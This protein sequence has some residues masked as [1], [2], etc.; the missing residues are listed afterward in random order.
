MQANENATAL[1]TGG[2]GFIGSEVIKQ[3]LEKGLSVRA[4][5]RKTSPRQ[6]LEGLKFETAIGELNDY[7][8][9]K[10]AVRGVDYVFHIAGVVS[11][12][13]REEYFRSNAEGTGNLAK[14]CAEVNSTLKRFIYVSSL[15]ASG[16]SETMTPRSETDRETPISAYGES[17]LQG[18][19]ELLKNAGSFCTTIVRPPA[20]YGPKDKGIF[21]FIRLI[22][23]NVM[24]VF[25]G[26]T[27]EKYYSIIHV[28]DLVRGIVEAGLSTQQ[29]KHEV[30]FICGDGIHSWSQVMSSMADVLGKR[31]FKIRIPSVAW[32]GIAAMYTGLGVVF[33]KQFPL[34]LDKLNE[35]R[36]DFWICSNEHAKTTLGFRPKYG[37]R[38][39]MK[40]TISW[41]KENKWL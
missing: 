6:N 31:P 15:A 11:A 29:G 37:L 26:K 38:D 24:P 3:L 23:K 27:S 36:P 33:K 9:L 41:Y 13:N 2:S 5:L 21:E 18:E 30:F 22:N 17:K 39:G 7:D 4:L 25:P 1:V 10:E 14:A 12:K 34:T 20:V 19:R 32:T 35:L 40:K 8:S 28:E 16:P